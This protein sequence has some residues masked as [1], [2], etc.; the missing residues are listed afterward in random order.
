MIPSTSGVNDVCLG[1][2]MHLVQFTNGGSAHYVY[3]CFLADMDIIIIIDD[4]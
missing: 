4:V 3:P 1:F 2:T